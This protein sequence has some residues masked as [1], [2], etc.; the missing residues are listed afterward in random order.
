MGA[1]PVKQQAT[2]NGWNPYVAG[3]MT[4]VVVVL[5]V[6][7][8]GKYVGVSTSFVRSAGMLEQLV[9]PKR[10]AAMDYFNAVVPKI[11]WQWMFV[12]GIFIGAALASLTSRTFTVRPVPPMWEERF[13]PSVGKRAFFATM[14]GLVAMFGARLAGG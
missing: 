2:E 13:G 7:L 3:A 9:A 4:G 1:E 11:E 6:W 10:V 5:S 12:A 8:A 14:G